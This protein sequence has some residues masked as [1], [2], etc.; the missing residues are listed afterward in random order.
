MFN[1]RLAGIAAL[2]C[3][4]WI[5]SSATALAQ[6][7]P[8]PGTVP[9]RIVVTAEP[10][11]GSTVP[12]IN[13]E[14]VTVMQGKDRATVTEWIPAQGDHAALE[15]FILIDDESNTTLGNQ[16]EDLRQF[17]NA[18]PPTTKVGVAYM[19]NGIARVVQDLTTDH[20]QAAK[21]LRLPLGAG[22]ANASPYFSLSDLVKKWPRSNVRRSVLMIS[23][24]IDRYYGSGDL[25]DPYLLAAIDDATRSGTIVSAIYTP[26]AGHF[27]HSYWQTYWGQ[28]YLAELADR[29][30]GEGYYIGFN[31]T[32]VSFSPYLEDLDHRLGHQYL[33]TFLA[34]PPKKAGFVQVKIST[35]VQNVDLISAGR[36]WVPAAER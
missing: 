7:A 5:F 27:G 24:G 4:T 21:S 26:G 28:I 22:G 15:L 20:E 34:T 31:G 35:E 23:D 29:T 14:D 12:V 8:A 9:T 1:F 11:H 6:Q 3:V 18:Q 16:L 13:R 36:V 32:P 30:G 10:R 25:E 19:Q 17:I 33:L 2:A